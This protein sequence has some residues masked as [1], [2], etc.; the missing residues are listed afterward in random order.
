MS[1]IR[2]C[3]SGAGYTF[4]LFLYSP[5]NFMKM[6]SDEPVIYLANAVPIAIILHGLSFRVP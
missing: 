4:P 6:S 1:V 3:F 5:E 2:N